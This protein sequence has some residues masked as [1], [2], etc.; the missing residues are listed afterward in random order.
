MDPRLVLQGG[1]GLSSREVR[2]PVQGSMGSVKS[3]EVA[4]RWVFDQWFE[5]CNARGAFLKMVGVLKHYEP[6]RFCE[7]E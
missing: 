2:A 6:V 5:T 3:C 7:L 4:R 1:E